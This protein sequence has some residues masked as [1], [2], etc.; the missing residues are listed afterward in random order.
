MNIDNLT[1]RQLP[2]AVGII[3]ILFSI[4]AL[5]SVPYQFYLWEFYVDIRFA[6]LTGLVYYLWR[7]KKAA[8]SA[9]DAILL[10]FQWR[11]VFKSFFAMLPV[12]G[13]A[14]GTG[15]LLD[16]TSYT[17][18]ENG[19]TILLGMIFDIPAVFV[20]SLTSIFIE[21]LFFRGMLLNAFRSVYSELSA[22]VY[23]A[24]AWMIFTIPEVIMISSVT[25]ESAIMLLVYHFSLGA[26]CS[27]IILRYS[28]I[29]IVYSIRMGI[30]IFTPVILSSLIMESD[31]F[32][33]SSIVFS[34]EGIL[35]SAVFIFLSIWLFLKKGQKNEI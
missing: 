13:I 24:S 17:P 15:I 25:W 19:M 2:A 34:T 12:Y 9:A 35:T 23:S 20:F 31:P 7:R 22:A 33:T 29:W 6:V 32:F 1:S 11:T 28:S 10:Q 8:I 14:I 21:E 30:I 4:L 18:V 16:E 3:S 26:L 5:F 27:V